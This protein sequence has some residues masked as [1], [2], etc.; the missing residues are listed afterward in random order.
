[1]LLEITGT[2]LFAP[3]FGSTIDILTSIISIILG[4]LSFGYWIGGKLADRRP[5][6]RVLIYI[7]LFS[8]LITVLTFSFSIPVLHL[9]S[10][11]EVNKKFSVIIA[12][13]I[14][15]GPVNILLGLVTPYAVRLNTK[16]VKRTGSVSGSIYSLSTI[17]SILGTVLTGFV[18]IPF[19]GVKEIIL[20]SSSFVF[21][22]ALVLA[23]KKID[24]KVLILLT[25]FYVLFSI[26]FVNNKF[27]RDYLLD[28]DTVY[29]HVSVVDNHSFKYDNQ[30]FN[31]RLLLINNNCCSG[32]MNLNAS[33]DL[34][35]NYTKLFTLAWK[36]KPNA[37]NFLMIGGGVYAF[38]KYLLA[39]YPDAN[40]DVVEI[41][42]K[43]IEIAEKFFFL[44][45]N[46]KLKQIVGD[47]RVY[48]NNNKK[49]YDVIIL[50]AFRHGEIPFY[51]TTKEFLN[52]VRKSLTSDGV[53]ITNIISSIEGENSRFFKSEAGTYSQVFPQTQFYQT[54]NRIK[55]RVQNII[56]IGFNSKQKRPIITSY[57]R[58]D[59]IQNQSSNIVL[60]DNYSPVENMRS[61]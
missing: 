23:I 15:F 20:F 17:G 29:Q 58:L 42:P 33:N 2:R 40:I 56:L 31:A 19:I 32:I 59:P 25:F 14:L 3:Y 61:R 38:P 53:L 24:F 36:Y 28:I 35:A 39:N 27:N 57:K 45:E 34:L 49:K 1:M 47:G 37:K 5:V 46:S 10:K 11:L 54:D 60:T 13:F 21:I 55:S 22:F 41:D 4:S 9:F 16:L 8:A 18:F 26:I 6:Y 48:I 51:L 44:K 43:I 12:S 30:T 7:L 52:N 50:D